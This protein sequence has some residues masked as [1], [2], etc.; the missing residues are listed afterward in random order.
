MRNLL[1]IILAITLFTFSYAAK[2]SGL[3]IAASEYQ[4]LENPIVKNSL[5]TWY[6]YPPTRE[7]IPEAPKSLLIRYQCKAEAFALS[8][9]K[10]ALVLKT[11][12][13]FEL[14]V[15]RRHTGSG[16]QAGNSLFIIRK[17]DLSSGSINIE[18]LFSEPP[19]VPNAVLAIVNYSPISITNTSILSQKQASLI[20]SDLDDTK[21]LFGLKQDNDQ[22]IH[23]EILIEQLLPL[24][25][26]N[27]LEIDFH[28]SYDLY[29][30]NR[31][32]GSNGIPGVTKATEVPGIPQ[33]RFDL[34]EDLLKPGKHSLLYRVSH[35]YPRQ[36][37]WHLP[38]KIPRA[39]IQPLNHYQ[40]WK[41]KS[42]RLDG[43]IF[44]TVLIVGI[45]YLLIF[46]LYQRSPRYLYFG[47][48][49]LCMGIST[50]LY[51]NFFDRIY[52]NQVFWNLQILHFVAILI[53]I[54]YPLY[55]LTFVNFSIKAKASFLTAIV[56]IYLLSFLFLELKGP[57]F[58]LISFTIGLSSITLNAV[59]LKQSKNP[60]SWL[61]LAA[62]VSLI[63]SF[64]ISWDDPKSFIDFWIGIGF[65][66]NILF[67]LTSL[68]FQL[69][70]DQQEKEITL[71]RN[72]QLESQK[73]RLQ[74][75]MLKRSI[76]PHFLM[77]TLTSVMEWVEENPKKESIL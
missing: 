52:Y 61:N 29:W 70:S 22:W 34:P 10:P 7:E 45:F 63:L 4:I 71:L 49:C 54:L 12:L 40:Y 69:K 18:L 9:E 26:T 59:A 51:Q 73:N 28:G 16:S 3:E 66:I 53:G 19:Q 21:A 5:H 36:A 31:Y 24:S 44:A 13:P 46:I 47:L 33:K 60:Q 75:Q 65:S 17:S 30:N 23:Q 72:A 6:P 67:L 58:L 38:G 50:A 25:E 32:I 8:F 39:S 27:L 76:Q 43:I 64:L 74:L 48:I 62:T 11:N 1:S 20:R 35:N 57:Q 77:N 68:A 56:A 15:N 55:H 37:I 2:D 42:L 14:F 41:T